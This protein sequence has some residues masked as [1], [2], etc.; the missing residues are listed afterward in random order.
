MDT[1]NYMSPHIACVN[2]LSEGVLCESLDSDITDIFFEFD[3]T[4]K[5]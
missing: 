2:L 5:E 4:I 1:K 3:E